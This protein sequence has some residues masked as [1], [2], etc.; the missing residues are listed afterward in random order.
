MKDVII[1]GSGPAGLSAAV[2][3]A[4]AG[5]TVSVIEKAPMSGG[6]IINTDTVDNYPGLPGIGGFDLGM[7]FRAHAESMDVEFL[8]DEVLEL[9]NDK[10]WKEVAAKEGR[11][12]AR[13]VI[14]AAGAVHA[15]LGAAG[16]EAFAGRGVSYC[17][18]CDGAFYRDKVTAVAGGGDTAL[19]E[20]LFLSK[21]CRKVYLIHRR[22]QLRGAQVLQ[23]R[24]FA[25]SNIE[26][27]WNTQIMEIR[28]SEQVEEILTVNKL[29]GEEKK[30]AVDG[31]FVA[32]GMRP[33]SE[34]FTMLVASDEQGYL[35]ADE[36]CC[37]N[38]A[39][40][41]AA[42]DIRTKKLRQVITAAADGANA[43]LGVTEYLSGN[44]NSHET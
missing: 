27:V 38:I 20:A 4:R 44:T 41:F 36:S 25:A 33:A 43:V 1:I 18:V 7:R 19:E 24:I 11:Y 17:A 34:R 30:T 29:T 37:T 21:I 6:Q 10:D 31:V 12:R 16:E 26:I 22:D 2:Y 42:G 35:V 23:K 14:I 40:I 9:K 32:V 39:G 28:G 3:A 5:L 15:R 13:A 8:E